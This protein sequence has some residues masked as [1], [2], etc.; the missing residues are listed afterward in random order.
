MRCTEYEIVTYFNLI[1]VITVNAVA[2][3]HIQSHLLSSLKGICPE[4]Y[5]ILASHCNTFPLMTESEFD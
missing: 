1:I 3:S 4:Q 2:N 5:V